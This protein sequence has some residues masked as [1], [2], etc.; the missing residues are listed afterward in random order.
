MNL[1]DDRI[2]LKLVR[3]F[4]LG[5]TGT[6]ATHV[7]MPEDYIENWKNEIVLNGYLVIQDYGIERISAYSLPTDGKWNNKPPRSPRIRKTPFK[8][9]T[10]HHSSKEQENLFKL[11]LQSEPIDSL[12]KEN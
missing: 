7:H 6:H 11:D 8:D 12:A 3:P 10:E 4:E 1:S 2:A 9:N 5:W